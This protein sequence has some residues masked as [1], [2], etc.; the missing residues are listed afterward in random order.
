MADTDDIRKRQAAEQQAD[1]DAVAR[2]QAT[3]E[4]L[5]Y[6]IGLTEAGQDGAAVLLLLVDA[7][8]LEDELAGFVNGD[9]KRQRSVEAARLRAV[10]LEQL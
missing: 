3:V 2:K 6:T 7:L 10:E 1:A 8:G 4:A 9:E 5:G